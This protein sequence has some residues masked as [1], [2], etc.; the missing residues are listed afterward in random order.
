MAG[1]SLN[2]NFITNGRVAVALPEAVSLPL[3]RMQKMRDF[4]AKT[5]VFRTCST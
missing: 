4:L 5:R 2:G 3:A 1:V